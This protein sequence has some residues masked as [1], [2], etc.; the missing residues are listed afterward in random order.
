MPKKTLIFHVHRDGDVYLEIENEGYLN[1]GQSFESII[2]AFEF[3][4]AYY[5]IDLKIDYYT[6]DF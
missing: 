1:D 3:L 6:H 2:I 5:K 4:L